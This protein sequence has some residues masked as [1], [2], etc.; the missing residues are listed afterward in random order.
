MKLEVAIFCL[1]LSATFTGV[2]SA[3]TFGNLSSTVYCYYK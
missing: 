2:C 1:L 3:P